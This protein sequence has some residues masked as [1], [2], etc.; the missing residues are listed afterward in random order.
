MVRITTQSNNTSTPKCLLSYC[1]HS[2]I[3][4]HAEPELSTVSVSDSVC[5]CK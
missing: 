2:A 5:L 1:C 4:A 3:I